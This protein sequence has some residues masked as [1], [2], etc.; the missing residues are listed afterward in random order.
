[1][2]G[3]IVGRL[4]AQLNLDDSGFRDGVRNS[5]RGFQQVRVSAEQTERSYKS[6]A[7]SAAALEKA[8]DKL[9]K[10]RD[11]AQK[12]AGQV[13]VAEQ[14]LQ[15]LRER[16]A[17]GSQIA[18]AE[19]RLADARRRQSTA[20][21][22]AERA[23]RSYQTALQRTQRQAEETARSASDVGNAFRS[24]LNGLEGA[25]EESGDGSGAGFAAGFMSKLKG[26]GGKGGAIGAA[27]MATVGVGVVAG[28]MI[29]DAVQEGFDLQGQ[30]DFSQ[31][32]FGF[33]DAQMKQA[34]Q[35]A[36]GAFGNAWGESV[37][38]N[39][40]TAGIAVQA[41]LID[42]DATAAEMQPLIEKLTFVSQLMGEEIPAVARAAGQMVKTGLAD[43]SA[44]AF[45]ILTRATQKGLNLSEDLLD[46]VTEYGTQFRKVGIDGEQAMGL[47]AQAVRGGA[48][49]TDIAADAIKEFSLRV[50]DGSESTTDAF[51]SLNLNAEETAA[52]FGKGG[53]A[54]NVMADEVIDSLR[55]IEDP[56]ERNR[57]G[58]ALFGTQW[59]DLGGAI[60][61]MDLSKARA[62]MDGLKGSTQGAMDTAGGGAAASLEAAKNRISMAAD[63]IKIKL[64]SAFA[65]MAGDAADWVS[66]N[67]EEILIFFG[68][69][70]KAAITGTAA[71]LDFG[72]GFLQFASIA[73]SATT[74]F[75]Q[76]ALMPF[77]KGTELM[78]E[79]MSHL[80]GNAGKM[81]EQIRDSAR[82]SEAFFETLTQGGEKMRDAGSAM[83]TLA[84]KIRSGT[85]TIDDFILAQ[86][87]SSAETDEQTAKTTALIDTLNLLPRSKPIDISAPGGDAV[88]DLLTQLGV[89]VTTDNNKN[90][91]V[92]SPLAP[93]VL[94][95]LKRLGIEVIN[96]NGKN[97]LVTSN[98][99]AVKTDVDA[100]NTSLNE[101]T[102]P[103]TI[104]I[105]T[106][107]A[108]TGTPPPTTPGYR[109]GPGGQMVPRADGALTQYA[110][111]GINQAGQIVA[112]A[113][114][115]A[116]GGDNI[117]WAEPETG[118]EAYISGKP[119]ELARNQQIW[120]EAGKRLGIVSA[121]ADGGI[122][123]PSDVKGAIS[124][125]Q[126]ATYVFGGWDGTWNTDCS[127]AQAKGA[128]YAA[129]GD[130]EAGGRFATGNQ[131]EA[132]AARGF[133]PGQAP[134]G[135]PALETGWYNDSSSYGGHTA[136]LIQDPVGGDVPFEMGGQ[137]N[138]G[139]VGAGA[140]SSR[141]IGA[142]D[143]AWYPLSSEDPS[144]QG[145]IPSLG[146]Q[147]DI[148]S[149]TTGRAISSGPSYGVNGA[150]G[151]AQNVF[152]VNWPAQ[153]AAE[154]MFSISRYAKGGIEDRAPGAAQ[155]LNGERIWLTQAGE[156][157]PESYIP[158]NGSARSKALWLETGRHLGM[159]MDSYAAGGFAGYSEDTSDALKPRSF[160]DWA[161]LVAGGGFAVASAVTPYI[162]MGASGQVTLGD[163][164]PTV[165]T[166]SNTIDGAAE[167]LKTL[168]DSL[169]KQIETT[170][171][172]L[173]QIRDKPIAKAPG[174][175]DGLTPALSVAGL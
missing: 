49:D 97:I 170:N 8:E 105:L 65:P 81:G 145:S 59:E 140:A 122:R 29:A 128:N 14:R 23:Q 28:K 153:M 19:E 158:L 147:S 132:L 118:W 102:K 87:Q 164:A 43:N 45:D 136:G 10:S 64:A 123:T 119:S 103:R 168:A 72:G 25:G 32:K 34:G 5:Q 99:P 11:A 141:D 171:G 112:R 48:R 13:R 165:D 44:E 85:A 1:M 47:I 38:A 146:S 154:P 36:G 107:Y 151:N 15:E 156:A 137:S 115:M 116:R 24:E 106:N 152:V 18:A 12:V 2:A 33:S 125:L 121:M 138:G 53:E 139:A 80:P 67:E 57:I 16:G 54:A 66:D 79:V 134:A 110:A 9:G 174:V 74:H 73:V 42:G 4:T 92:E 167:Q 104:D 37:Q 89:K 71:V 91:V 27:L 22:A 172:I 76:A 30:R 169:Q 101:T 159:M 98:A 175:L 6:V 46:T 20:T 50:I 126:G 143:F 100:L 127:G 41:G 130:T 155:V 63:E 61:E 51:T 70:A 86:Q 149:T 52:E 150:E 142:T 94:D 58:V 83:F 108:V 114:M 96:N 120:W 161:A 117:M 129:T 148:P 173:I 88:K 39:L 160:Y 144:A 68:E 162:G 21:Q 77:I 90:I 111:G 163:L 95:T 78:G 62:E 133:Q 157:G 3:V 93:A 56:V 40:D 35:A 75:V 69:I 55:G 131:A 17:S 113:P 7:D 166:S 124:G 60:N 135:V 84:D 31:A 26:L 82:Q 109:I